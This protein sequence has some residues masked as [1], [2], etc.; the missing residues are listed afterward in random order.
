MVGIHGHLG[1][2]KTTISKT[3]YN[4]IVKHFYGSSFLEN[5]REKLET[6]VDII[7]LQEQLLNNILGDG[8]WKVGNKSIGISLIE[9]VSRLQSRR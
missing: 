7:T 4:K 5:V 2:G 1:V 6:N 9:V 3:V 8:S